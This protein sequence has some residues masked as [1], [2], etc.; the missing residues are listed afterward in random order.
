MARIGLN[1]KLIERGVGQKSHII[2]NMG[3]PMKQLVADFQMQ[4]KDM[5][6]Q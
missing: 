3:T 2:I 4:M 5:M 6:T 1:L